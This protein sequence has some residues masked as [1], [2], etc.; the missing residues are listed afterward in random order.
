MVIGVTDNSKILS[1]YGAKFDDLIL[2]EYDFE[3]KNYDSTF[4]PFS[5]D[6]SL[7]SLL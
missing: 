4:I 1:K 5:Q 6:T 2:L 3:A 7:K